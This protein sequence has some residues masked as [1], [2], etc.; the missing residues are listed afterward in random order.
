MTAGAGEGSEPDVV[1]DVEVLVVNPDRS[2]LSQGY[3]HHT[4]SKAW[5]LVEA[6]LDMGAEPVGID[7]AVGAAKRLAGEQRQ[8]ADVL[9]LMRRLDPQEHG[10]GCGHRFVRHKSKL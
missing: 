9:W 4:L 7:G 6:A 5:N 10:I 2:T 8:R 3:L 1:L